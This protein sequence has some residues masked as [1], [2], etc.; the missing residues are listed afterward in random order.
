MMYLSDPIPPLCR[1]QRCK[2]GSVLRPLPSPLKGSCRRSG[3]DPRRSSVCAPKSYTHTHT[4][5]VSIIIVGYISKLSLKRKFKIL[6]MVVSCNHHFPPYKNKKMRKK[7]NFDILRKLSEFVWCGLICKVDFRA[8]FWPN[9]WQSS[10]NLIVQGT[11]IIYF[12]FIGLFTC[13][14]LLINMSNLIY[15]NKSIMIFNA[16]ITK[17]WNEFF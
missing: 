12:I 2:S 1:R 15:N 9:L 14:N 13:V 17:I 11:F 16:I 3:G 10:F 8:W 6:K 7:D 5:C 4:E